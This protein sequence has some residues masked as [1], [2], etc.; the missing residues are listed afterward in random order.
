MRITPA[1]KRVRYRVA[2][3]PVAVAAGPDGAMWFTTVSDG[4]VET[5]VGL[6]RITSSGEL[7]QYHLHE[8]CL[9]PPAGLMAG[10]ANSLLVAMLDG[11]WS[12]A[13]VQ[14]DRLRQSRSD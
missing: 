12:L 11:P 8:T 6:G 7:E 2:G 10:P 1:G 14:I 4:A 13:R 5:P 3:E 9:A